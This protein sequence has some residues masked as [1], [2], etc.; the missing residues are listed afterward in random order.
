MFRILIAPPVKIL[1]Q[2]TA[3]LLAQ[4]SVLAFYQ[5]D[6][7]EDLSLQSFAESPAQILLPDAAAQ[8]KKLRASGEGDDTL[9]KVF[10]HRLTPCF[11]FE[12][13]KI[14]RRDA[15]TAFFFFKWAGRQQRYEH[16][17]RT[18]NQII[19][20]L[21][22]AGRMEDLDSVLS[23]MVDRGC[24]VDLEAAADLVVSYAKSGM[25][26]RAQGILSE[27][28]KRELTLPARI[29]NS[30]FKALDRMH[31]FQE[32]FEMVEELIEQENFV[33]EDSTAD[34]LVRIYCKGFAVDKGAWFL[35]RLVNA[36]VRVSAKTFVKLA[37][38]LCKA[39]KEDIA[40]KLFDRM[41]AVFADGN[42][43]CCSIVCGV[44]RTG[45]FSRASQVVREL[46]Q[47]GLSICYSPEIS[48]PEAARGFS[49][50]DYFELFQAM[51]LRPSTFEYNSFLQGFCRASEMEEVL[52]VFVLMRENGAP[53]DIHTYHCVVDAITSF[54]RIDHATAVLEAMEQ[55]DCCKPDTVTYTR[56]ID[57]FCRRGE[58]DK[59]LVIYSRMKNSES[60]P[61]V[62]TFGCLINGFCKAL[63]FDEAIIIL[64]ASLDAGLEPDEITY[65]SIIDPLCNLELWDI[66]LVVF[67]LARQRNCP[68]SIYLYSRLM[69]C[70][71]KAG[72]IEEAVLLLE[73]M[74][75]GRKHS[76]QALGGEV[77]KPTL[78]IYNN[79]IDAFC[80]EN[81]IEEALQMAKAM[82]EQGIGADVVTYTSFLRALCK[83][84]MVDEACKLLEM[85]ATSG[86][87]FPDVIACNALVGAFCSAARVEEAC[88]LLRAMLEHG[89]EPDDLTYT[90]VIGALCASKRMEAAML[91]FE[92]MKVANHT[93]KL[94]TY[95]ELM[96]GLY[97]N[98]SLQDARKFLEHEAKTFSLVNPGKSLV[99]ELHKIL[100]VN[101]QRQL[102]FIVS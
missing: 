61:D 81:R 42:F 9:A 21:A 78:V 6:R 39:G 96:L 49:V 55:S 5:T 33:P 16:D 69:N 56:M 92:Y 27:L 101:Q 36:G 50:S 19:S 46:A 85:M 83:V 18:Y 40:V 31:R 98:G 74:S 51:N 79:V 84:G 66:A 80:Q 41:G 52:K 17:S 94:T 68:G 90:Q 22:S 37:E 71:C 64:K 57:G 15:D 47:R 32:V 28:R 29:Y 20:V 87:S 76:G 34:L 63:K 62:V 102:S 35:G 7:R 14:L 54:G 77:C 12:L 2:T 44:V 43:L 1:L 67:E 99:S 38:S 53:E 86:S 45:Q 82:E 30:V 26:D 23:E 10:F 73:D 58:L 8:L 95:K 100:N 60:S 89:I 65:S 88:N 13:V 3:A 59:A 4:R 91:L 48:F 97:V 25:V 24:S 70:L 11:V 75:H 72:K 93:P